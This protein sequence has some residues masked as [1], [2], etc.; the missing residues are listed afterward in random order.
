MSEGEKL[1]IKHILESICL[2]ESYV[3]ELSAEEFLEQVEKQ[4]L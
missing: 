4:V 3:E 1:F 2:I